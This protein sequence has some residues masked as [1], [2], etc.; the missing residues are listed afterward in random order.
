MEEERQNFLTSEWRVNYGGR[1]VEFSDQFFY[2]EYGVLL[3]YH[4]K[5]L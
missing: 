2:R 4:R 3:F 1:E 5:F